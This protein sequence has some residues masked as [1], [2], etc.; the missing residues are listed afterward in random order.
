M[1]RYI[2]FIMLFTSCSPKIINTVEKVVQYRDTTIILQPDTMVI[3][4]IDTIIQELKAD[5]IYIEREIAI[6]DTLKGKA[7]QNKSNRLILFLKGKNT[8]L[9][10]NVS[11]LKKVIIKKDSVILQLRDTTLKKTRTILKNYFSF[12]DKLIMG[13]I[14]FLLIFIIFKII[15][16]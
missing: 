15:K 5:S 16:D 11:N 7:K 13:V 9:I 4:K 12:W 6:I 8:A 14:A 2:L 3:F 10:N 1:I